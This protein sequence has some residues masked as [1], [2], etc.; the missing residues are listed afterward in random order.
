MF[1]EDI[2]KKNVHLESVMKEKEGIIGSS[3]FPRWARKEK[4][5]AWKK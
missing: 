1:S 2:E 3:V 4:E 5:E